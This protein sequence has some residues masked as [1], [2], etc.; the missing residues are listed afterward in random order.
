MFSHT[1]AQACVKDDQV[2]ITWLLRKGAIPAEYQALIGDC[3]IIKDCRNKFQFQSFNMKLLKISSK[4][5]HCQRAPRKMQQVCA[6]W[7]MQFLY[8][9]EEWKI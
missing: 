4:L 5:N 2:Q 8:S 9:F 6:C 3:K 1:M 7:Q